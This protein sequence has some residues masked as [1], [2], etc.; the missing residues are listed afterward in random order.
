[1]LNYINLFIKNVAFNQL[2]KIPILKPK[3]QN[4]VYFQFFKKP[5]L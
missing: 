2:L 5:V 4:K 1:M 3:A